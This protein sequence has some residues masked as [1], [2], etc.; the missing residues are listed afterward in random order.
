MAKTFKNPPLSDTVATSR[1]ASERDFFDLTDTPL[2]TENTE[3]VFVDDNTDNTSLR[4]TADNLSNI[5]VVDN[6]KFQKKLNESVSDNFGNS[7]NLGGIH[8]LNNTSN[9]VLS[10]TLARVVPTV[11]GDAR[12]TFVLSQSHL[13]KLRDYVHARRAGG[14]YAYSQK[15]AMQE[16]L[17]LL[18][19]EYTQHQVA[20]A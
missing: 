2:A 14:D 7:H 6:S 20:A 5:N 8:K 15:Q 18:F 3:L 4:E 12:Q 10:K 19:A 13:E 17:D 9:I 11:G 1:R 16:A